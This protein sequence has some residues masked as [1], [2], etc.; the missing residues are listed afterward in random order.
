MVFK[1]PGPRM[2]P[3]VGA[4]LTPHTVRARCIA[5]VGRTDMGVVNAVMGAT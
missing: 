1:K 3:T 2:I 5:P 4:A